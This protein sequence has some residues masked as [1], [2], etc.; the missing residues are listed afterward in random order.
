[1]KNANLQKFK[2]LISI[3]SPIILLACGG[4]DAPHPLQATTPIIAPQPTLA[5]QKTLLEKGSALGTVNWPVGSSSSGGRGLP[6][7]GVNCLK[8]EDYHIHAHLAIFKNGQQLSIPPNIGLQGCAYELH[9]HDASGIIHVETSV[10]KRF[11]LAQFFAVW[12]QPFSRENIAGLTGTQIKVFTNDDGVLIE[13]KG[14]LT[15]IE[16]TPHRSFIIEVGEPFSPFP[17][18]IWSADL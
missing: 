1:M 9:T 5:T 8:T 2:N 13:Q 4:G 18:Y 12:G 14:E 6:V 10:Y 17:F 11:T 3:F 15:D 7:A 16:I